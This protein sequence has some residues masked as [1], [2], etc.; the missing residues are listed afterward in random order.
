MIFVLS[1][2]ELPPNHIN[3]TSQLFQKIDKHNK[4]L[5]NVKDFLYRKLYNH[6]GR[7]A[8]EELVVPETAMEDNIGTTKTTCTTPQVSKM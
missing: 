6:L 4:G 1:G 7:E 5:E 2:A 8:H 3:F